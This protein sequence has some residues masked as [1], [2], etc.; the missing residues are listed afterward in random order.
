MHPA[1]QPDA[2]LFI[3][4]SGGISLL[5]IGTL[6]N[7]PLMKFRIIILFLPFLYVLQ[8]K[9]QSAEHYYVT[10]GVY[11]KHENAIHSTNNANKLNF[12]AQYAIHP[13]QKLYYVYLLDTDDKRKAS[14]FLMK[15]RVETEFKTAWIYT[16]RLGDEQVIQEIV[17]KEPEPVPVKE[18][19]IVE[20]PK[21]QEPIKD[22]VAEQPVVKIDSS[23]FVKKAPEKKPDG[24]PFYFKLIDGSSGAEVMGE[25]HL[26]GTSNAG[27]YQSYPVNQVVYIKVP[28]AGV[29]QVTTVAAGY[30]EMKRPV[31][32]ND[33]AASAAEIGTQQEAILSFPLVKVKMGDYIEFSNV[34]FITNSALLQPESKNELDGLAS[35]MKE[36]K[37]YKVKI[38][39]HCNGNDA[40]DI[41]SKGNSTEF[42]ATDAANLRENAS[43]KRLTELRAEIVKEYLISQGIEAKRITTKAE[44]GKTMI[45]PQ[46]STL[47]SRNDR[48]EVEVSRGR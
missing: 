2:F 43:A 37:K 27:Q 26:F 3:V 8:S 41:V 4:Y 10:I 25:V 23:A 15:I 40:R 29:M 7:K 42:F 35:L 6:K 33:P 28:P 24:K 46:N 22:P 18:E 45:Y 34:R 5:Y 16:G 38:H 11:N 1:S 14:A 36:N 39:G 12:N 13:K 9:A 20:E 47:S 31:N 48:V 32:L 44:G 30:R 21:I 19:P 17:K